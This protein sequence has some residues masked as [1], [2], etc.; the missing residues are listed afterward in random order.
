[1]KLEIIPDVLLNTHNIEF[2]FKA[3]AGQRANSENWGEVTLFLSG[4]GKVQGKE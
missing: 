1:M 2:P 4:S 3:E